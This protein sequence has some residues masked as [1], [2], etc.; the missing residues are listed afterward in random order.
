MK[1]GLAGAAI[2]GVLIGTGA[3]TAE[4]SYGDG[5]RLGLLTSIG[6]GG[7]TETESGGGV[8][9]SDNRATAGFVVTG[10]VPVIR[11]LAVGLDFGVL[12][13]ETDGMHVADIDRTAILDITP[14]LK[15]MVPYQGGRGEVFLKVPVGLSVAIPS[16]DLEQATG[17]ETGVGWTAA[18]LAG[19][20][21]FVWDDLALQLELGWQG[22]GSNADL[23]FGGDA[24]STTHQ[25]QLRFGAVWEF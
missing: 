20:Q 1:G 8:S 25:F 2:L 4:A 15:G 19:T 11:Y 3:G 24:T 7:E 17:L 22:H 6:A 23:A 14:V 16:R 12:F 5:F 21:Y 13:G 9:A 18:V 10:E